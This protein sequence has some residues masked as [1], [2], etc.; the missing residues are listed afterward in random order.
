MIKGRVRPRGG[1]VALRAILRESR[2]HVI[3]IRGALE[4]LQ[5]AAD[6]RS[7]RTR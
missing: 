5:V 3:G 6:A 2:L 7:V 1:G 4:I